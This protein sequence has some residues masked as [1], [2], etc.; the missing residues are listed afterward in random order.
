MNIFNTR[1]IAAL[2]LA[3]LTPPATALAEAEPQVIDIP[4]SRPG[5]PVSLD[6]SIVSARIEVIGEDREDAQVEVSVTDSQRQ[7]ITPSGPKA[8]P[9]A[10][11]SLEVEEEDN[12][13]EVDVDWRAN[14][15]NLV[16]RIP[17]RAD[18][19][20]STVNNG[21]LLVSNISGNLV[22]DNTNG[23][24]TARNIS[25]SVIADSVNATIDV[26]F[27]RIAGESPMSFNSV[28]GDIILGLPA[29][30][31]AQLHI[32]GSQGEISSDF[33]V[34]VLPSQPQ[35]RR[36]EGQNG[37]EV[38]VESIIVADVNG[39]GP[40]IRLKTLHG[41]IDIRRAGD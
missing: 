38:Q 13:I 19:D 31:G 12:H 24:I 33:E 41:D 35:V 30:A 8:I 21:E 14:R 3:A 34:E 10:A 2:A 29:D 15:V 39:G 32:D 40:V 25:G 27:D 22:L 5:E 37:V 1:I 4:L 20:L 23:P 36:K 28:N 9:S 6:V 18:L 7:I 26:S 16:A 17:R 11:Y